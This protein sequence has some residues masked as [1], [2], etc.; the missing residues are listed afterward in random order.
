MTSALPY[1]TQ[2][3]LAA[4]WLLSARTI[5]RWRQTGTGPKYLKLGGRIFYR[6]DDVE[7]WEESRLRDGTRQAGDLSA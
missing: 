1:L 6:P 2:D 7:T 4:R 5:E 3:D